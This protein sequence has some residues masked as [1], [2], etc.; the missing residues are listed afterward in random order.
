[1]VC[2][3]VM[4]SRGRL[5]FC[6]L[7]KPYERNREKIFKFADSLNAVTNA[8]PLQSDKLSEFE[9]QKECEILFSHSRAAENSCLPKC[10]VVTLDE[11]FPTF[12]KFKT[13]SCSGPTMQWAMGCIY[14]KIK[15]IQFF[16]TSKNT[17]PKAPCY[18]LED[19]ELQVESFYC[20]Q[21][22]GSSDGVHRL[23]SYGI[24]D[25]YIS[26]RVPVTFLK[27]GATF[28]T[29][30]DYPWSNRRE[31][32]RMQMKQQVEPPLRLN[33][34]VLCSKNEEGSVMLLTEPC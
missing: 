13:P 3:G 2:K 22:Y 14:L 19:T 25:T 24:V 34:F 15:E 33:W 10:D 4:I 18:V 12:P 6:G 16:N 17:L 5:L 31:K 20:V 32:D 30:S 26:R 7:L 11:Y 29:T 27:T 28:R 9:D 21:C 1:M 23:K 8:L